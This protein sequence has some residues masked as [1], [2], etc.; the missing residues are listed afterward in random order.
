[1]NARSKYQVTSTFIK[2][3]WRAHPTR[4]VLA[5][6]IAILSIL[7]LFLPSYA[8]QLLLGTGLLVIGSA[9]LTS[10][11]KEGQFAKAATFTIAIALGGLFTTQGWNLLSDHRQDQALIRALVAEWRINDLKTTI[12]TTQRDKMLASDYGNFRC[13]PRL[14]ADQLQGSL[15]S[16]LFAATGKEDRAFLEVLFSYYLA[17][18]ELN[19]G[20]DQLHRVYA[21]LTTPQMRQVV[22]EYVFGVRQRY[23]AFAEEHARVGEVLRRDYG[24]AYDYLDKLRINPRLESGTDPNRPDVQQES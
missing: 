20:L 7:A 12:I 8:D 17:M 11:W 23:D 4:F 2:K 5:G 18:S 3:H 10:E 15:R 9:V 19:G 24:W 22:F 1:M 14:S 6:T 13:F 16:S 21:T